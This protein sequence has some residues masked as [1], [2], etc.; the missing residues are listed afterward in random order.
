LSVCPMTS[1]KMFIFSYLQTWD[2][3]P[4]VEFG[5]GGKEEN[6]EFENCWLACSVWMGGKGQ[7]T[8]VVTMI[9]YYFIYSRGEREAGKT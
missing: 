7:P 3:W 8:L 9:N 4:R 2:G 1:K 5:E 6:E